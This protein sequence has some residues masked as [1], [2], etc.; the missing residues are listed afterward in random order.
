M[1]IPPQVAGGLE[2]IQSK[3]GF[4]K[5]FSLLSV[6]AIRLCSGLPGS[7][8]GRRGEGDAGT[9]EL[10]ERATKG[11]TMDSMRSETH[12]SGANCHCCCRSGQTMEEACAK[13]RKKGRTFVALCRSQYRV[14]R[15]G[16]SKSGHEKH[17]ERVPSGHFSKLRVTFDNLI[18][19]SSGPGSYI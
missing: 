19:M 3:P 18:L 14:Y 10:R 2:R 12:G 8:R 13:I 17:A 9:Y 7:L 1:T 15:L 16:T 6:V 5:S 4:R 11:T